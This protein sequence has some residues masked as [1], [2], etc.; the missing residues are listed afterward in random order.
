MKNHGLQT[1]FFHDFNI[2]RFF[3]VLQPH[4]IMLWGN[5]S[6]AWFINHRKSWFEKCRPHKI[7]VY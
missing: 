3:M 1:S 2:P 6:F 4:F 5:P 7:M